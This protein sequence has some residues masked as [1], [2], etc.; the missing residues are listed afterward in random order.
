MNYLNNVGKGK[1]IKGPVVFQGG[2]SKNAAVAKEFENELGLPVHVEPN[3]HL[4]GA[5]GAAVLT[6][7]EKEETPFD[8]S[9]TDLTI[10]TRGVECD[11]CPN[12]CEIICVY[13][14]DELLDAWGN[15]CDNGLDKIEVG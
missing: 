6:K 12:T 13:R 4:L 15:R 8:F 3:G 10:E 9:I 2:V 7:A 1:Q 14:E 11:G 5:L